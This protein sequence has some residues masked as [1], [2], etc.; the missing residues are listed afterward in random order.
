MYFAY[1]TLGV[2]LLYATCPRPGSIEHCGTLDDKPVDASPSS[3]SSSIANAGSLIFSVHVQFV[4]LL[5]YCATITF[6]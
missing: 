5:F 3:S 2:N 1:K 4:L 6:L